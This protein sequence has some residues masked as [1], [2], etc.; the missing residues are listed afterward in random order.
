MAAIKNEYIEL[1]C[2]HLGNDYFVSGCLKNGN[3]VQIH[4]RKYQRYTE[5]GKI[6]PT[7]KGIILSASDWLALESYVENIDEI[8]PN[9]SK[10][11]MD[12]KWYV[13]ND[14]FITQSAKFATVDLRRF[15]KPENAEEM[16][17][18]KSGVSLTFDKW[19]KLKDTI[20][21][22]REFISQLDFASVI[23]QPLQF[24]EPIKHLSDLQC[25]CYLCSYSQQQ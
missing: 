13:G 7:K 10:L 24:D 1:C 23:D 19:E 20:K 15:W 8:I 22:I 14:V 2:L 17:P 16:A 11:T 3:E 5:N 9:Q 4:I 25:D 21:I 18:T 12:R 6:F